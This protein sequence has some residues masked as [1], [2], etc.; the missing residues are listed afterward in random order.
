MTSSTGGNAILVVRATQFIAPKADDDK[1]EQDEHRADRR[2]KERVDDKDIDRL[3][4]K[5]CPVLSE[6]ARSRQN[7]G[8][9]IGGSPMGDNGV[10]MAQMTRFIASQSH[11]DTH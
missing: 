10:L 9:S 11:A 3:L 1:H 6:G 4:R 2:M 5:E 8:R 7:H